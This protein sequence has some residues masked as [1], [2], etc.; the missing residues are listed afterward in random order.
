MAGRI[1][2]VL[3]EVADLQDGTSA[4]AFAVAIALEDALDLTLS[5]DEISLRA[6]GAPD[7]LRATVLRHC[8]DRAS[9]D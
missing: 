5:D 7:A 3:E 8:P 9:R 6:L 4:S 2:R 1:D